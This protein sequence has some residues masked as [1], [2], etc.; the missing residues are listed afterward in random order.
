[1]GKL[2]MPKFKKLKNEAELPFEDGTEQEIFE[3]N[4]NESEETKK[5]QISFDDMET[6]E[7]D[8]IEQDTVAENEQE[9]LLIE[10]SEENDEIEKKASE[11]KN[12]IGNILGKFNKN[13]TFDEGDSNPNGKTHKIQTVLIAGFLVPVVFLIILG[14]VSYSKASTTI[15][16]K[17]EESS[18]SAI[19]AEAL[20][21]NL[22][23]STVESRANELVMDDNMR[24]Y[25]EKYYNKNTSKAMDAFR[26]V[27]ES[28]I[29]AKG[30][31]EY[32]YRCITVSDVGTMFNTGSEVIPEDAY[33][34]IM[35]SSIGTFFSDK[36]SKNKWFGWHS[37]L[38]EEFAKTGTT[39]SVDSKTDYVSRYG[40]SFHQRFVKANGFLIMDIDMQTIKNALYNMNFGEN[41]YKAIVTVDGREINVK[42]M[43]DKDGNIYHE[44]VSENLIFG[45]EFY[46]ASVKEDRA[47]SMVVKTD[48]DKYL[49]VYSPIGN[50]GIMICSLIPYDNIVA[51]A[52]AIRNMTIILVLLATAIAGIV[53]SA[54]STGIGKTLKSTIN[55]LNKVAAGDL[56]VKFKTKRKDEFKLLNNSL[57]EMLAGVRE[58]MTDVKGFS[59]EVTELSGGVADTS[60]LINTAM[61]DISYAVDEVANGA[62]VQAEETEG[63]KR[64]MEKFSVQIEDVCTH[65]EDLSGVTDKA[66]G[67]VQRGKVIIE[68]LNKQSGI[69]V[70]L[71]K[72]LGQDIEEVKVKSDQI[73]DIINVINE[74][75]EQ[76]NLL[77]LNASIE[78]ARAGEH[79]RG[80]AVVAD[81]IRKLADQSVEAANQ[82]KAIVENIRV[83]TNQTIASAHKTEEFIYKQAN[84]LDE[85]ITVF[86]SINVCVDELVAGLQ[87]MASNMKDI[88]QGKNEIEESM[89]NISAVSEESAA[90]TEEMTAT[91]NEQVTS[92]AGLTQKA[93]HL[94]SRVNALEEAMSKFIVE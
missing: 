68:D 26:A 20:Y 47:G 70:K 9:S 3:S 57:N 46:D 81:E 52:N 48:G 50:T 60:S 40:L 22:L 24:S 18:I 33:A 30:S 83:T 49:Y 31:A 82:I 7:T 91:I 19:S 13:G 21:F 71:T 28:L 5:E 55:S 36:K 62:V 42:E 88:G 45:T 84:S 94:A 1:M 29:Y 61:V 17:Y 85:T 27:R 58:I 6:F 92:V 67:A 90:A 65:A 34:K 16:A 86:G 53:A 38:D 11:N 23:C 12:I 73:E 74:I 32:M 66:I 89:C 10:E 25:Y 69:T 63:S 78:A 59:T 43:E 77:S 2:Q 41:S 51:D 54:I 64:R 76:T 39:L 75:A 87:D 80:F 79:G 4:F 8:N 15:V 93:E 35:E 56:T 72:E 37:Y 44:D 14:I